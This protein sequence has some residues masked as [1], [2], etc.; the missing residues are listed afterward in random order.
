MSDKIY[1]AHKKDNGEIQT[2]KEHLVGTAELCSRFA[3]SFGAGD[4]G[5]L[6]GMAHDIGKYSDGFQRRIKEDGPK[7]DHASAGAIECWKLRQPIASM[8]IMGHHGGIMNRGTKDDSPLENTFQGR[9]NRYK[10]NQ[11][12]DYSA[13]QNECILPTATTT[14]PTTLLPFSFSTR[15]LF[16][17]LVDADFLDTANFMGNPREGVTAD[18]DKL[19]AQLDRYT[20]KWYPPQNE[21]NATRCTILDKCKVEGCNASSSLYTLT[22]PTGGGKTVASLAFALRHA[23]A[24]GKDHIIYVIPYASIIDQTAKEFR[25]IFGD[26]TVLE[27][28]SGIVYD[29]EDE[30]EQDPMIKKL[31]Y[32]TENWDMPII[33]TTAVQFFDSLY[34]NLPS[35]CRKLHNIANSVIIF[36]EAQMLPL[37]YLRPCVYAIS[38][39]VQ[40]YRATAVLCTATQPALGEIFKVYGQNTPTEICPQNL[41]NNDIFKRVCFGKLGKLLKSELADRLNAHNQVLCIVNSRA[42]AKELYESLNEEGRYHLST[43]MPPSERS[44]QLEKIRKALKNGMPCR[45]VS[46]SLIEAGVDVDFPTVYREI[47]GLDSILQA[48]GRCNRE[49]KRPRDESEVFI[50]SSEWRAPQILDTAIGVCRGI[51]QTT[52]DPSDE[53]TISEYFNTYLPTKGEEAQ[54][55]HR[56]LEKLNASILPFEDVAKEFSIIE[57]SAVTV[58]VPTDES[59][60]LIEQYRSGDISRSLMRKLGLYGVTVYHNQLEELVNTGDV[61]MLPGNVYVLVNEKLYSEQTGLSLNA[62]YGKANFI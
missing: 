49:G 21:L 27:H 28:H 50:F 33:V 15:M 23:R 34:S 13:W 44:K 9:L 5:K 6:C 24:T 43:L 16:S 20:E 52:D 8:C 53:R 17:C 56:I 18:W 59:K 58:Y 62:E 25:N 11:K 3:D 36:D 4:L 47:S 41:R 51:L 40:S 19:N 46:T 57:S 31:K 35:R 7:V 61:E 48:A 38:Q 60:P 12:Y 32:A 45:V 1:I 29:D 22:V 55:T 30:N 42:A 26:G 10:T 2:V 14:Y 39:L 37:P 54:D